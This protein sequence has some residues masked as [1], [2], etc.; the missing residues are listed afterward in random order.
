MMINIEE[1]Q[2]QICQSYQS[3]FV[4]IDPNDRV[5]FAGENFGKYPIVGCKIIDW[6][7]NGKPKATWCIHC[8]EIADQDTEVIISV[9]QLQ[10]ELPEVVPFL[11]LD[12]DFNFFIEE[13]HQ[14]EIWREG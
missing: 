5:I 4:P 7:D 6:D 3:D 11:A 8:G 14:V 10:R 9:E 12:I 2:K 13:N 1:K